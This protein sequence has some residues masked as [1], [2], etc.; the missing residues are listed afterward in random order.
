MN[1]IFNCKYMDSQTCL[2]N[3]SADRG[4]IRS[5][6]QKSAVAFKNKKQVG[7]GLKASIKEKTIL[8]LN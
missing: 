1:C 8:A 2:Y 3:L 7:E 4:C 6:Q 5:P